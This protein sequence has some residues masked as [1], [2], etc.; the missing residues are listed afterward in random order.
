[1][2]AQRH[3]GRQEN[4]KGHVQEYPAG[5]FLVGGQPGSDGDYT[6]MNMSI[7]NNIY[8]LWKV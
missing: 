1:M 6:I 2:G 4:A 8:Q 7:H 3:A 5:K